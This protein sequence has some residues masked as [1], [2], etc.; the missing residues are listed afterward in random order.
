MMNQYKNA[1]PDLLMQALVERFRFALH[2]SD[3]SSGRD[4]VIDTKDMVACPTCD[5]LHR[6]SDVPQGTKARCRR[7]HAVLMTPRAGAMTQIIMLS[8]TALV[9]MVA[10][11]AFPFLDLSAAGLAQHPSRQFR[12]EVYA[13]RHARATIAA[14]N[15]DAIVNLPQMR[16]VIGS[17]GDIAR[18]RVVEF[19]R[20]QLWEHAFDRGGK[21]RL[22]RSG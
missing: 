14:C 21:R 9:L 13:A 12:P 8:A 5:T 15:P 22:A 7:C 1:P 19:N 10:A 18:P 11:V 20:V 4:N 3:D 6:L 2:I 17:I 16:A